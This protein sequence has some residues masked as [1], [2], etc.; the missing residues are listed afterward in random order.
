MVIASKTKK[1]VVMDD[2]TIKYWKTGFVRLRVEINL[3]NLS[4]WGFSYMAK[5]EISSSHSSIK[6]CQPSTTPVGGG[7][8]VLKLVNSHERWGSREG[9][10]NRKTSLPL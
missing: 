10:Y 5:M 9:L 6:L 2:F 3:L 7:A 4:R 8:M 1:L